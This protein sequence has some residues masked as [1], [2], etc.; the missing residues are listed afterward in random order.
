MK[1]LRLINQPEI[2][3]IFLKS[4]LSETRFTE[5]DNKLSCHVIVIPR[6]LADPNLFGKWLN[7]HV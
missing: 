7:F 5:Q 1:I 2:L 4:G 3:K 6:Q